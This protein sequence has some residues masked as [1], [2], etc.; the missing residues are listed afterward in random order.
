MKVQVT[1]SFRDNLFFWLSNLE[2]NPGMIEKAMRSD[3]HKQ[4]E[5]DYLKGE[6]IEY[7]DCHQLYDA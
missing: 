2:G 4:V 5:N 7:L 6:I 1:Y 3:R